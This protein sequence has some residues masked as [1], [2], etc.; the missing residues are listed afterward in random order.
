MD[1]SGRLCPT[2]PH[3]IDQPGAWVWGFGRFEPVEQPV[4]RTTMK[5]PPE[6]GDDPRLHHVPAIRT[7][8]TRMIRVNPKFR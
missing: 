3:G 7:P 2:S 5:A 6:S 4:L 1:I 8:S